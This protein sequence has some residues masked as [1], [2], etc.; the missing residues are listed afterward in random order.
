MTTHTSVTIRRE[1]GIEL[2]LTLDHASGRVVLKKVQDD[3]ENTLYATH[4]EPL[5]TSEQKGGVS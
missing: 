3:G 5:A 4:I 1:D 2:H